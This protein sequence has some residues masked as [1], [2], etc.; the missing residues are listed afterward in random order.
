MLLASLGVIL[1]AILMVK[2]VGSAI[3]LG[4]VAITLAGNSSWARRTGP[5]IFSRCRIHPARFSSLIF[6]LPTKI[7][8]AE[9]VFVF[10]FVD[11]FDN[12]GTL[13]GVCEQGGFL[14]RWKTSAR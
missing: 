8:L 4:I 7:G 10:F 11:L 9:L 13:V 1:I 12:V 6:A 5:R 14:A 2:R 3:L